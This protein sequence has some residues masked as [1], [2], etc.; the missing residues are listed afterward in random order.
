MSATPNAAFL[1]QEELPE[2]AVLGLFAVRELT[3]SEKPLFVVGGRR[4]DKGFLASL[5]LPAG[6]RAMF[7]QN[8]GSGF[9]AQFLIDAAGSLQ[10]ADQ[11]APIIQQLQQRPRETTTLVHW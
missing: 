11:I 10:Q 8:L 1:K 7:Y 9:S 4:I 5:E 6:M 2:G 3:L